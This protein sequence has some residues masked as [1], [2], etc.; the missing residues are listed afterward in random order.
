[1]LLARVR[2]AATMS[3][4]ILFPTISIALGWVLLFFRWRWLTTHADRWLVAYRFWTQ[5]L[6]LGFALGVMAERPVDDPKQT[7]Q[8]GAAAMLAYVAL[9]GYDLGVGPLLP[10][11]TP[12]VSATV[13]ERWFSMPAF[14]A[15][16]PSR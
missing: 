15:L 2:F 4:H 1:V 10:R 8:R 11:G 3:F 13:R 16:L 12:L 9:D 6:A 14:I 7:P 5:V